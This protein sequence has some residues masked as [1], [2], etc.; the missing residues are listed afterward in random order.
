MMMVMM[1]MVMLTNSCGDGDG[2]LYLMFTILGGS[3][4]TTQNTTGATW[5]YSFCHFLT[6][7]DITFFAQPINQLVMLVSSSMMMLC[8]NKPP[9]E[10]SDWL[11]ECLYQALTARTQFENPLDPFTNKCGLGNA[12]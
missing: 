2:E 5:K 1:V 6:V 11:F 8:P 7:I 12:L 9:A 10:L 3:Y 4:Q